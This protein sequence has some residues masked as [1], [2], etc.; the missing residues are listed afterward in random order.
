MTLTMPLVPVP[1]LRK[2]NRD[3]RC[4][5]FHKSFRDSEAG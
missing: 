1:R 2:C 4:D 5:K 3:K